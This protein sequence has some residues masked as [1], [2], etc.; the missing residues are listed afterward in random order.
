MTTYFEIDPLRLAVESPVDFPW[1]EEVRV[2]RRDSLQPD[3]TYSLAFTEQ[4]QPI[5]GQIVNQG[6]QMLVMD[7]EGAECRVHLLPAT[8]EPFA[9]TR[10]LENDR[11]EILIDSRARSALKWDRNLLGLMALEHDCLRHDAFLLHASF[12]ICDG[13]AILFSAPSGHGKSTQADLWEEYADAQIVNGDRALV[14]C[15]DGQWFAGGF[16]VCGS[17]AHCLDRTA[18]L[19]ALVYLEKAPENRVIPLTPMQTLRQF[20]SQSFVNRWRSD[21]CGAV[22][23]LL[24]ALS[25]KIPVFHYRCTKEPDAVGCLRQVISAVQSES[26]HTNENQ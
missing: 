21:D 10:R 26:R 19:T 22:S 14:F 15:R 24:I 4:F 12:V 8:G 6:S 18:P 3:V 9:L 25:E 7:A 2:F 5:R 16:P 11:Y 13:R 23:N 20:Y 17:S 1:T